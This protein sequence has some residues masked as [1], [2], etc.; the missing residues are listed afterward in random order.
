[1]VLIKQHRRYTARRWVI[2]I[3]ARKLY[4]HMRNMRIGVIEGAKEEAHNRIMD[5][6]SA[7][8]K[9]SHEEVHLIQIKERL[10]RIECP[11]VNI[12]RLV[13]GQWTRGG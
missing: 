1:M 11:R 3:F 6:G 9:P 4:N 10:G 2:D 5:I 8:R 12:Y 7:P 13:S